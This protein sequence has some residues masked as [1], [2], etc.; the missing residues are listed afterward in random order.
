MKNLSK[1]EIETFIK[2]IKKMKVQQ[3]SSIKSIR[4]HSGHDGEAIIIR[5]TN[6]LTILL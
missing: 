5:T 1:Q 4:Y 2:V 3:I 6:D